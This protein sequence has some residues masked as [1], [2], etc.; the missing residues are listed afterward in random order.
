MSETLPNIG[1]PAT[2]ALAAIG[3]TSLD[4]VAWKSEP[5]LLALHG[6]GPKAIRILREGLAARGLELKRD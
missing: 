5:E 4:Q 3:I 6:V 1:K 2:R